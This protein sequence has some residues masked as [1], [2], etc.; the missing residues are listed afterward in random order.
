MRPFVAD[1]KSEKQIIS[2]NLAAM[3][4]LKLGMADMFDANRKTA[5]QLN[6]CESTYGDHFYEKSGELFKSP[7]SGRMVKSYRAKI[8]SVMHRHYLGQC[9]CGKKKFMCERVG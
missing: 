6:Q 4:T 2:D 3:Q 9:Q 7:G 1:V 8:G 5:R